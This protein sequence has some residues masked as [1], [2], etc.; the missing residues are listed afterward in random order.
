M[1]SAST[2][3]LKSIGAYFVI[4]RNLYPP[5]EQGAALITKSPQYDQAKKFLDY[6]LSPPIQQQL[7]KAGLTPVK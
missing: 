1:T 3:H 4:P 6:L 7:A 2:E 5:I